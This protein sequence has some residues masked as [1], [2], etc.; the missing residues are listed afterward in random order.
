MSATET[1]PMDRL[2]RTERQRVMYDFIVSFIEQHGYAPTV[3]EIA[4]AFRIKSPNGVKCHLNALQRKGW[5]SSV[6]RL[7]RTI[8]PIGGVR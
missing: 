8:R 4:R 6:S 1:E 7:S 2:E 3:R 5:I